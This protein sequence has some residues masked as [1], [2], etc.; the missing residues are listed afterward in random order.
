MEP[1]S[2]PAAPPLAPLLAP[3][4]PPLGPTEASPFDVYSVV[5]IIFLS[6]LGLMIFVRLVYSVIGCSFA[7]EPRAEVSACAPS[8]VTV[9]IV[10]SR[11]TGGRK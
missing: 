9:E 1:S 7:I 10:E 2:P 5:A 3:L 6:L 4:G 8:R 11:A